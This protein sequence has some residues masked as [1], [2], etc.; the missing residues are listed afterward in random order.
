MLNLN[1]II[2]KNFQDNIAY[3]EK[4]H[5][6]VF[7]KV[8]SL[9]S[10]IEN[11]YYQEKY[12]LV[13]EN[14]G[15]DVKEK[16]SQNYLYHKESFAHTLLSTQSI[17]YR[18][19]N[20][21]IEAFVRQSF[22]KAECLLLKKE[23]NPF[24]YK[25]YIASILQEFEYKEYQKLNKLYKFIF[26]GV[27]LGLHITDIDKEISANTYFIVEDDLELFRLSL[28]CTN[29]QELSKNAKLIFS[30]FESNDAFMSSASA[31][32]EEAYYHNHYLKFF[33]LPHHKEA[34][35]E[36]FYQAVSSQ[37]HLRFLFTDRLLQSTQTLSS[38]AKGYSFLQN[39][40]TLSE[41]AF[42][43]TPVLL[44]ASGPS[45]E[46]EIE[47]LKK[48]HAKCII[49]AV[50]SSLA[51]LQEHNVVPNIVVHMDPFEQSLISFERV[52]HL[53]FLK[54][55]LL[56]FGA[57]TPSSIIKLFKK[58]NLFFFETATAYKDDSF[59][60]FAPCVGSTAYQLLLSLQVQELY[61][62]GVDLALNATDGATHAGT[63]QDKAKLT[64]DADTNSYKESLLS[65][66]GNFTKEVK[67]TADFY[68]SLF[69][70][71]QMSHSLKKESQT[72][73][74]LSHGAKIVGCIPM[75][76][77]ALSLALSSKDIP[78]IAHLKKSFQQSST[79]QCSKNEREKI[80]EQIADAN[81]LR[82]QLQE[83]Q[84]QN[85][86]SVQEYINLL[87]TT[88]TSKK[89]LHSFTLSQI[90]DSYYHYI[91]PY[92]CKSFEDASITPEFITI[93]EL[94]LT[95]ILVIIDYYTDSLQKV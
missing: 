81:S 77:E 79:T 29:Y 41:S 53:D 90:L 51:F 18:T 5:K 91:F 74:N 94:L 22:S 46:I 75:R 44:L 15:F 80:D 82:K 72:V 52:K 34:S 47:W 60:T 95:N 25:K 17:N 85:I 67:T 31:F 13:Y 57:A 21:T 76:T 61:L 23:H 68:T 35:I 78:N 64:Q 28:F 6:T 54:E 93:H 40:P 37:P 42:S 11:N 10:A 43:T 12:E 63:H 3:L 65:V 49:V 32:L 71:N 1:A 24:E 69:A 16:N 59:K 45:L 56:L 66:E 27:G 87:I 36:Q 2:T 14:D 89:R 58:E 26:F 30:V 9:E 48:N 84:H 70:I 19:D 55:S 33:H 4:N 39:K 50:S 20:S 83:L 8:V 92:I 7:D 73:Y 88:T 38:I 62:L 86:A